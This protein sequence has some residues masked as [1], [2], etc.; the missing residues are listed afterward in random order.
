MT[1]PRQSTTPTQPSV[2]KPKKPRRPPLSSKEVADF[3]RARFPGV[4]HEFTFH[5][6]RNWAFDLAWPEHMIAVEIES[7]H[8]VFVKRFHEDME[9]YNEGHLLGWTI[10]RTTRKFIENGQFDLLLQ[11]VFAGM[12]GL[13]DS[14]GNA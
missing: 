9:K 10:Y 5:P 2:S 11:R 13:P 14:A 8:H 1:T 7:H 6:E 4:E 3:F 12:F